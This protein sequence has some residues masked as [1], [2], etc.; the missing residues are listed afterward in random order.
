MQNSELMETKQ[1][2]PNSVYPKNKKERERERERE[3][4][5]GGAIEPMLS[6]LAHSLK[7]PLVTYFS[8]SFS[9]F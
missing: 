5:R 1:A 2:F 6:S 7:P 8:V 9:L 4:G 3:R